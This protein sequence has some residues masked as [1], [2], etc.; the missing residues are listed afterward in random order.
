MSVSLLCRAL[1]VASYFIFLASPLLA[2]QAY[3]QQ[4]ADYA[5]DIRLDVTSH[6]MTGTQQITYFNNSPDTLSRVFYHL[7]YNAFQPGSMMDER[8]RT[9]IDPDGRVLD[10][11]S[12]LEPHEIGYQHIKSLLQDGVTTIFRTEGTILIVDLATPILPNTSTILEME[13]EAQVPV[14]IRRTGRNNR[15]GIAYS[16]AQWYPRLA[17]FD[18]DGWATHPYV[19]REFHGNFGDFDVRITIDRN[20]VVGG[21]GYLQNPQEIGHG[22]EDPSLPLEIPDTPELT[23]HFFA[24][25]VIDFMWGADPKFTHVRYQMEDGPEIHLLYVDRPQ[26]LYWQVLDVFTAR[27]IAFLNEYLGAYPYDQFTIIQGG[28]GGMEYPMATLITG[29][30]S[31]YS[32]VGVTVHEL[33]HMWFQSV[34]ATNES[35]YHFIDEGFTVYMSDIVMQYLFQT[36]GDPHR[37]TYLSYL[38]VIHDQLEEPMGMHADWFNTNA[39][40]VTASYRKGSLFLHQLE[41]I[42]GRDVLKRSLQRFFT[43]WQFRHPTPVDFIR[44]VERESGMMLWWYLHGMLHTTKTIDIAIDKVQS[45]GNQ[46]HIRLENRGGFLMPVDLL[47][48]YSDGRQELFNIPRH[49][50]LHHKAQE[51]EDI[52]RTVLDAW[53]WTHRTYEF[54]IPTNR[55]QIASIE[56]D[57]TNRLADINRLNN[58]WPRPYQYHFLEAPMADWNHY[59]VGYRPAFWFGEHS[60]VMIGTRLDGRY[61]FNTKHI[62]ASLTLTSGNVNQTPFGNALDVDYTLSFRDRWRFLGPEGWWFASA[63]RFYGISRERVGIEKQLGRYGRL[64][65]QRR[66]FSLE[67]F[68]LQKTAER[69]VTSVRREWQRGSLAGLNGSLEVGDATQN[70]FKFSSTLAVFKASDAAH[71]FGILANRTYSTQNRK[72]STRF[73]IEATG[74]ARSMPRQQ[75][76]NVAQGTALDR[77]ENKTWFSTVNLAEDV[78]DDI[79][80]VFDSGNALSVYA[81][82]GSSKAN[83]TGNNMISASIWNTYKP[84]NQGILRPLRLEAYAGIGR[85]WNGSFSYQEMVGFFNLNSDN[86]FLASAGTGISFRFNELRSKWTAQSAFLDGLV[87][88]IRTP[89]YVHGPARGD[90]LEA[91]FMFGVSQRF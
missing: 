78:A 10:R 41:Y 85:A 89:L 62:H 50:M 83:I 29:H 49:E 51:D 39:A 70:G 63:E 40:Y 19:A 58:R 66:V 34:I 65:R 61:L 17:A 36:D 45:S 76:F 80:L 57:P 88:S 8:S 31:L 3:W 60:G 79:N 53:F 33:L 5:M 71:Q 90:E 74:G 2:Q 25:D 56:I 1:F 55:N 43:D 11:I 21:T 23:W 16:M 9:I 15:E 32:L 59:N 14:Q 68:H 26:T 87:L 44:V 47:V 42:V 30:R 13:F 28:D 7:Y 6:I 52:P 24:P 69:T 67:A 54:T 35:L 64:E 77:W 91:R 27:A 37:N 46:T 48:T 75:R 73:G 72:F 82:T 84:F 81:L 12:R 22:Y 86:E 4:R 20:F 18:Q 38:R